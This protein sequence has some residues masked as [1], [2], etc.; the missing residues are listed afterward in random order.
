M[1]LRKNN[2][3]LLFF[4]ELLKRCLLVFCCAIIFCFSFFCSFSYFEIC[5]ALDSS[6][7][8][9]VQRNY[10]I[11]AGGRNFYY[12]SSSFKTE[13]NLSK[14]QKAMMKNY[15]ESVF[16]LKSM[17]F[18]KEEIVRYLC[19]ESDIVLKRLEK[20][21][22]TSEI[23]ENVYVNKN[24]CT[25]TF[26]DGKPEVFV[27]KQDFF[28]NI[29]CFL[30]NNN[31]CF[32]LSIKLESF[33]SEKNLRKLFEEKSSFST[34]F[35]TSSSERKNN[36]KTALLAFDGLVLDDGEILSFNETTGVRDEK[37]GYKQAK[38]I[39][40]GTF[41]LGYGG[42]VCQVSTTLYNACLLSGLEILEVHGHSL[43]VSYVEPSFDAMVN[44]G[45]SDLVIR[46][47]SGGKII[48]TTSSENDICKVKIFGL[49]N[50]YKITRFSEK[51]K[52][53][54]AIPENSSG[55]DEDNPRA[56]YLD[57]YI[58]NGYLNYYDSSGNLI[59]SKMVRKNDK[60]NA[61]RQKLIN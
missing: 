53:I 33:K 35:K 45:S 56:N 16:V 51:I 39:S 55:F 8:D 2:F 11:E 34:N 44:T 19:P 43:P 57:G 10:E 46:N 40:N 6:Q 54:P 52:I 1:K 12:S 48:F 42:G 50:K 59:M 27:N 4:C 17:G 61:R 30:S 49:K 28:K 29:F 24:K 25:L 32:K 18:S 60:Y 13:I 26:D 31:P 9:V 38:I 14:K 22:N 47:N 41:V 5:S 37:S 36:I 3:K 21:F 7:S 58:S 15:G 20:I 23:V